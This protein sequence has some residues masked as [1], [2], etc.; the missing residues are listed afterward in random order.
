M[1]THRRCKEA[2]QHLQECRLKAIWTVV[3][4]PVAA[5][6][7]HSTPITP[8]HFEDERSLSQSSRRRQCPS[9]SSKPAPFAPHHPDRAST[10]VRPPDGALRSGPDGAWREMARVRLINILQHCLS[11]PAFLCLRL[12]FQFTLPSLGSTSS[13]SLLFLA[14]SCPCQSH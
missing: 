2:A 5:V 4:R 9:V 11:R 12:R 14:L 7:P 10:W 13:S 6:I 3:K 1:W 8:P